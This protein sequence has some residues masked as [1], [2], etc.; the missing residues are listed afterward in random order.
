M[1]SALAMNPCIDLTLYIDK[2]SPGA[3]HRAQRNRSDIGGK[4]VNVVNALN[5]LGLACQ[6][7][8]FDFLENG[9]VLKEPLQASGIPFDLLA[10]EGAI[11]TN[12]KIF[13][14]E[15]QLMTEINQEGAAVSGEA[16][17]ALIEKTARAKSDVLILS[18]SLP[19]GVDDG[20][21]GEI[22]KRTKAAVILDAYGPALCKGLMAGAYLIKPNI[23]ELERSFGTAAPSRDMQIT[24][25]R[26]LLRQYASL[27]A[28][29][30][31]LG[32]EGALMIGRNEAYYSPALDI[33]V[34]GV[35]GA[36]DSMVA[37]IAA[38]LSESP[39]APL[40]KLL[41]FAVAAAAAS[42]IREGTLMATKE[43]FDEM[44]KRVEVELV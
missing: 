21:Y 23:H 20:V 38:L 26:D 31:S 40:D 44:I 36:G 2:L 34:R 13:E 24:L 41:K 37:G 17:L 35:Q 6:L 15:D 19:P 3:T 22:I 42:L 27:R 5:N 25:C 7:L 28:I 33:P 1:I 4:A 16:V 18:G 8:G 11:R 10:V 32:E 43:G 30:L 9:N 14:E 12:I 29:C 39:D